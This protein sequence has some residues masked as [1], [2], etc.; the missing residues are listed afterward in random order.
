MSAAKSGDKIKVE[1]RGTLTNGEEFDNWERHGQ[2]LEITLG[3]GQ[4]I[5]GFESALMGM[6]INEEKTVAIPVDKAYGDRREEMIFKVPKSEIE[7]DMELVVGQPM[8]VGGP[9]GQTAVVV[10]TEITDAEV[11]L[12][13]NHPLAGEDLTFELKLVEIA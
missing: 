1:Y 9:D 4:V 12:D 13:A 8:Q 10:V 7:T 11:T 6:T 5:P 3:E 2:P